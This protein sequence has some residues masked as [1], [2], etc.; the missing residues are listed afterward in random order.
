M[1]LQSTNPFDAPCFFITKQN[2]NQFDYILLSLSFQGKNIS[3]F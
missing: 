1:S 2:E 3:T